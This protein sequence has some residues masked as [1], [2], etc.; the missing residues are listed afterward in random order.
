MHPDRHRRPRRSGALRA[1][2]ERGPASLPHVAPESRGRGRILRQRQDVLDMDSACDPR[3][4]P[5]PSGLVVATGRGDGCS[6]IRFPL[7]RRGPG[8]AAT[9]RRRCAPCSGRADRRTESAPHRRAAHL[10][11]STANTGLDVRGGLADDPQDVTGGRLLLER[12][13]HLGMRLSVSARFFS[14]SSVNRRTFSMAMTAW[15]AKVL[16]NSNLCLRERAD[17]GS[18]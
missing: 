1:S 15:L 17:L 14:C 6:R 3:V 8:Y 5:T 12:L 9:N 4:G 11:P 7:L 10:E 2:T 16:S 18:R 13:G